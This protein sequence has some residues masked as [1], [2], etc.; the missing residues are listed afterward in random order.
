MEP[1]VKL[2]LTNYQIVL[3]K[4]LLYYHTIKYMRRRQIFWRIFFYSKRLGYRR[5]NS[6]FH[7]L[8]L[9]KTRNLCLNKDYNFFIDNNTIETISNPHNKHRPYSTIE[10][11]NTILPI[12]QNKTFC[13]LNKSVTFPNDVEWQSNKSERLWM[14]NLHYFD[15]AFDMGLL[16]LT[17]KNDVLFDNFK[18]LVS[19]WIKRNSKIG[20]C[21]GWEPYPV[22]LR[23]SNWIYSYSLFVG[24]I[25]NDLI[26]KRMFLES[27]TRQTEFLSKNVEYH[28]CRNHLIKNGKALLMSGLF[29]NGK[30]AISWKN[31]GL[32]ILL[33]E[34]DEQILN[35]GGHFER[36]PMY[37]MIV[38]QD[39]I[40][41][42]ILTGKND[43]K[44]NIPCGKLQSMLTFLAEIIHPDN[45]IP[46]L[47]DA[48]FNIAVEPGELLF[49]GHALFRT[50]SK[51]NKLFK[52]TLYTLILTGNP[53][54]GTNERKAEN[55]GSQASSQEQHSCVSVKQSSMFSN[56]GLCV[57]RDDNNDKSMI[58]TCKEPTP[59]Y[60]PGHSHADMLSYELSLGNK[61]FIVDSGAYNYTDGED[62]GYFRG[63]KGHNTLTVNDNNQS[64]LW[65]AFGIARRAKLETSSLKHID[66]SVIF[67]GTI[68]HAESNTRITHQ[69]CIYFIDNKFWIILD[70]IRTDCHTPTPFTVK[71]FIHIH[72]DMQVVSVENAGDNSVQPV[73]IEDG[74][75]STRLQIHSI[76]IRM[77]SK[78]HNN[79]KIKMFKGK[80]DSVQGWYS[81]Y[82]GKKLQSHV[83][84]LSRFEQLPVYMGYV[85]YPSL[86]KKGD[87][88][89]FCK[90]IREEN[91]DGRNVILDITI[92]TSEVCYIIKR[93]NA[94]IFINK[95]IKIA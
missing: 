63:T 47:N 22:S 80:E 74:I 3:K 19:D 32:R 78:G 89:A 15:Y 93:R 17:G 69:R 84:E 53:H 57:I 76:S 14:Y 21:T 67:E 43:I 4:F 18:Y 54:L 52:K 46:L 85:L 5:I 33:K 42:Y 34:A 45:Q 51:Y 49:I 59:Q 36:S 39:Y 31:K 12:M 30:R 13:F 16:Y 95:E 1:Q 6:L 29:F 88:A 8:I 70:T 83:I 72:P 38:L 60:L 75:T 82:F 77:D 71:S 25:E 56:S 28:V 64:E 86:S 48:A 68:K 50:L 20:C 37:H 11:K 87:V 27:I 61:R 9:K 40:E 90:V 79:D 23:I 55:A 94:R 66:N 24:K 7:L 91:S 92:E 58:I 44:F 2:S 81:P 73:I 35:D 10:L 41:M 65:G 62:R 26:F